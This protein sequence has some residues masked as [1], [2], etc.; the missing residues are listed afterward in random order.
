MEDIYSTLTYDIASIKPDLDAIYKKHPND[1]FV[2]S[3]YYYEM[4][5][6]HKLTE[7]VAR[8]LLDLPQAEITCSDKRY[9]L[10]QYSIS[11]NDHKRALS[12][13]KST[14]LKRC[15]EDCFQTGVDL[16]LKRYQY[17]QQLFNWLDWPPESPDTST[18]L[19]LMTRLCPLIT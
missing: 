8:V 16:G 9:A 19:K 15:G 2:S 1:A 14:V 11:V 17:S 3:W 18:H 12:I 4:A 5:V 6:N 13:F 7:N 10:I